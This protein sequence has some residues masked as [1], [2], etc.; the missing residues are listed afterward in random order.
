VDKRAGPFTRRDMLLFPIPLRD[1]EIHRAAHLDPVIAR[2]PRKSGGRP[3]ESGPSGFLRSVLL[4]G[5][6]EALLDTADAAAVAVELID[7]GIIE[8]RQVAG[9]V[10]RLH[11]EVGLQGGL[12]QAIERMPPVTA[13]VFRS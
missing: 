6:H 12:R 8:F 3:F 11:G 13:P 7:A 2:D 5:K 4:R 10:R 1:L 9:A